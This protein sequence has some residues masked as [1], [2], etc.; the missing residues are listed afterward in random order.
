M[1]DHWRHRERKWAVDATLSAYQAD[2]ARLDVA[3][4]R[5]SYVTTDAEYAAVLA[6]IKGHILLGVA[7]DIVESERERIYR[8]SHYLV[9]AARDRL[10][11]KGQEFESLKDLYGEDN[12]QLVDAAFDIV[13][14]DRE[15]EDLVDRQANHPELL[16]EAEVATQR[17]YGGV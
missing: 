5:L 6:K 11:A 13:E 7:A 2:R 12:P 17:Y 16:D 4:S 15:L 1:T 8:Q 3:L 14:L 10:A 9:Q